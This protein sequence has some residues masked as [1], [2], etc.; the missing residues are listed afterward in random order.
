[1]KDKPKNV[2]QSV[3]DRLKAAAP[4]LKLDYNLILVRYVLERLL[5][6]LSASRHKD[7]FALKGAM[8]FVAWT[9]DV[10]RPTR[11]LDLLG[12]GDSEIE[13]IRGAFAD[14]LGTQVPDD[15]VVFD[16]NALEAEPIRAD[17]LYDGVRVSALAF[18]GSARVS[19]QIDIGFGDAVT[20]GLDERDYPTLLDMPAPR[21]KTYPR[22]TVVAEKF[23]AIVSIGTRTSRMKDFYDLF[24]LARMFEF[25]G[26]TLSAA[27]RATFDRRGTEVPTEL[28]P[29]LSAEFAEDADVNERWA[30]FVRRTPLFVAPPPLVKLVDELQKFLLPPV[31]AAAGAKSESKNWSPESG[32]I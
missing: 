24:C 6:R 32:W 27:I 7:R 2:A 5:F 28:P 20:P 19:V 30:A 21:L 29:A 17:Q 12:F 9:E 8:L 13:E 31:H 11:D 14:I 3:R 23:E 1:M 4:R 26:K 18:V 10:I 15:G 16:L 25:D 22:E